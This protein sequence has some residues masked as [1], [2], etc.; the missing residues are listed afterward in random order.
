MAA[1]GFGKRGINVNDIRAT[2]AAIT[3]SQVDPLANKEQRDSRLRRIAYWLFG[4]AGTLFLVTA[5]L[6]S[7]DDGGAVAQDQSIPTRD[8]WT[9]VST[10]KITL[11]RPSEPQATY[12]IIGIA[13]T[14]DGKVVAMN[15]R[16]SKQSGWDYTMRG[17]DCER[18][19]LFTFGSGI[20]FEEM[21]I[22]R[23][24]NQWGQLIQG[25]SA[26]QVAAIAC[27]KIGKSLSGVQ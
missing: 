19:K 20:T 8:G 24:D 12:T 17:Y 16:Y 18:G 3:E 4:V 25:S 6:P 22:P 5:L 13:K 14:T 11:Q 7:P 9:V 2:R 21:Q 1:A 15:T 23:P 26:T 27:R 10:D